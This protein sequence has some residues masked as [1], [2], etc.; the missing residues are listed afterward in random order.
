MIQCLRIELRVEDFARWGSNKSEEKLNERMIL[1]VHFDFF[2]RVF[3]SYFFF[4]LNNILVGMASIAFVSKQTVVYVR[5]CVCVCAVHYCF[6][7]T[8]P[9]EKQDN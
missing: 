6:H 5:V 8:P 1:M 7:L 2:E 3:L 9:N 4:F